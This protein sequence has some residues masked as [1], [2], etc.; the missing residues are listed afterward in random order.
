MTAAERKLKTRLDAL[1][2]DFNFTE[3]VRNDPIELPQRYAEPE[4]I[5]VAGL[6]AACL[7]YGRVDQ[8]KPVAASILGRM[9][10]SPARY[11]KGMRPQTAKGRLGGLRYRFSTEQDLD[12]MLWSMGKA[13]RRRDGLRGLFAFDE[14]DGSSA[15]REALIRV[16]DFFRGVDTR[17]IYG[18]NLHPRGLLHLFPSPEGGGAAKRMAL[19]L[20]WMVRKED[21]D[22]GLWS[23]FGAHRLV[24]PLDT[25]I[26]RIS[27]CIGLTGRKAPG[28]AMAEEITARLRRFCPED[29]LRYD[30][31][32]CHQ[33]ISGTC[34][35]D[36]GGRICPG[37]RLRTRRRPAP[38]PT[39][40][41]GGRVYRK[42]SR[43]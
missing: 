2:D 29:P 10:P 37:C 25:H 24:I 20:R 1:Y 42:T 26:A 7:A 18:R 14:A 8:F 28:W 16:A 32:L 39:F 17:A 30:F 22:F 27:A 31:A 38:G 12:A 9:G 15:A 3:R 6:I 40:A 41:G 11:L 43:W 4:D 19:F 36:T 34:R 5:E 33:G 23:D 13:L 35:P 21:I